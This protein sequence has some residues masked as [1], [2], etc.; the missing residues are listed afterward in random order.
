MC[1]DVEQ[2]D[3]FEIDSCQNVDGR[4]ALG[5]GVFKSYEVIRDAMDKYSMRFFDNVDC[6]GVTVGYVPAQTQGGCHRGDCCLGTW[7]E[8][9]TEHV[10]F[11]AGRISDEK[12]TSEC[13]PSKSHAVRNFFIVVIVLGALAGI[14]FVVY[15]KKQG[16]CVLCVL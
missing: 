3:V 15:K 13:T 14:A 7:F 16:E 4:V 11:I 1:N 9:T 8:G 5:D 12:F 10:G 2:K 6:A